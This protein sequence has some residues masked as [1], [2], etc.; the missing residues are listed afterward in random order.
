MIKVDKQL[1]EKLLMLPR[2]EVAFNALKAHVASELERANKDFH[3]SAKYAVFY[4]E[5]RDSALVNSGRVN[6]LQELN[7]LL[8]SLT[9][10]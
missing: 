10:V 5:R 4:P 2:N 9:E 3:K 8:N 7:A 1:E 6:A